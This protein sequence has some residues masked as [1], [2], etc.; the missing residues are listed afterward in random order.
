[1][2]ACVV[3]SRGNE[4]GHNKGCYGD[5]LPLSPGLL[6]PAP[7]LD[8]RRSRMA[9]APKLA[10][11]PNALGLAAGPSL[12]G[13]AGPS[14]S[15]MADSSLLP[16]LAEPRLSPRPRK[17]LKGDIWLGEPDRPSVVSE[18]RRRWACAAA[19]EMELGCEFSAAL[20]EEAERLA[21]KRSASVC[22]AKDE[23]RFGVE[24]VGREDGWVGVG[25][26]AIARGCAVVL[27]VSE[28]G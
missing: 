9:R 5:E 25:S 17:E 23:R 18:M 12:R 15:A 28:R 24:A 13:A 26:S 19:W 22:P 2:S 1:M 4:G 27:V 10:R 6:D 20:R 21:P 16:L 7:L 3:V 8:D 14:P 11:R